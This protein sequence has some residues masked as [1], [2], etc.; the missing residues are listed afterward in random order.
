MMRMT[1]KARRGFTL[2]ELLVVVA[3]IALLIGV[4]LPSLA[5]ARRAA[6]QISGA[7]I[8]RQLALG[9]QMYASENRGYFPGIN[10]SGLKAH[11]TGLGI[12]V[13]EY[14]DKAN[15][16]A[17]MPTQNY[18]WITPSVSAD[19]LPLNRVH[20]MAYIFDKFRDP[21]MSQTVVPY[22]GGSAG[23]GT[24]DAVAWVAANPGRT[25]YGTSF[26]MPAYFQWAGRSGFGT[27]IDYR[28]SSGAYIQQ[29]A[30][31]LNPFS[32]PDS[33]KPRMD[34]I[35]LSSEKVCVA[36]GFR[37]HAGSLIDIDMGINADIYGSFASSSPCFVRSR[38]YSRATDPGS[39]N[40][41]GGAQIPLS[42]RHNGR[43]NVTFW[44]MH[45]DSL[46][47]TES[48]NP[49]HWF[50]SESKFT[51]V[52]GVIEIRETFGYQPGDKLP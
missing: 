18:D 42:Y 44:D 41:A 9:S 6:W 30:P 35:Q 51:G 39:S 4:L 50:P 16:D 25:L 22:T 1:G 38:A 27:P 26:L 49:I 29:N 10:S 11:N 43:M 13:A 52:D 5:G 23:H 36:D 3:I 8:Q 32:V 33:Y 34:A 40:V 19:D 24:S 17:S 12:G 31:F 46:T 14:L 37:F 45:G 15:Q 28:D 20:R 21:A 48:R 7:N 2:I 47:D